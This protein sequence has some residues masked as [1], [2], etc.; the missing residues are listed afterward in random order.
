MHRAART[1]FWLDGILLLG[2]RRR[3]LSEKK[4]IVTG[5]NRCVRRSAIVAWWRRRPI[6]RRLLACGPGSA[7]LSNNALAVTLRAPV[8]Q[9][10]R[11]SMS[12]TTLVDCRVFDVLV[13]NQQTNSTNFY[14]ICFVKSKKPIIFT[15]SEKKILT[16]G[17]A[18]FSNCIQITFKS[19]IILLLYNIFNFNTSKL[20]EYN[21]VY[22]FNDFNFE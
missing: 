15:F 5:C 10:S 7:G 6:T 1:C 16:S 22:S 18:M 20:N 8:R 13:A 3:S 12:L 9:L 14:S 4:K 11:V 21:I 2:N 17:S 19:H